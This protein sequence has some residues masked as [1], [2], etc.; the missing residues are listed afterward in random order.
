MGETGDVGEGG[1]DGEEQVAPAGAGGEEGEVV[2]V[3]PQLAAGQE[4]DLS[5]LGGES[6]GPFPG[7]QSS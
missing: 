5:A 2:R 3:Q 1:E 7:L 4:K 6:S